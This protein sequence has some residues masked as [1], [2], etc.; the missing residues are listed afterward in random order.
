VYCKTQKKEEEEEEE[1][2]YGHSE[3]KAWNA[4][5]WCSAPPWQYASAYSFLLLSSSGAF[6]LG[7]V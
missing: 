7:V 4:D 2:A 6:H 3:Q 1:T 5:I